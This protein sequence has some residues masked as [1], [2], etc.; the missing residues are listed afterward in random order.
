M[1]QIT[2]WFIDIA[3]TALQKAVWVETNGFEK[4]WEKSDSA[5]KIQSALE[6]VG[7]VSRMEIKR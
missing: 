3:Y 1:K 7:E 4:G 2:K 6:I 5:K